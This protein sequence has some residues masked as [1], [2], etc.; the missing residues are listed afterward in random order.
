MYKK[1]MIKKKYKTKKCK[2]YWEK[3]NVIKIIKNEESL[4]K[5]WRDIFFQQTSHFARYLKKSRQ[6]KKQIKKIV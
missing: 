5:V 4:A 3:K 6:N 2:N 1:K